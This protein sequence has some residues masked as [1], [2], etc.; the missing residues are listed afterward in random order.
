MSTRTLH[1]GPVHAGNLRLI[2]L[3]LTPAED[4]ADLSWQDKALCAEVD[5][6][7]FYTEGKGTS[8][9]P[10]ISV[11]RGCDVRVRCLEYALDRREAI[12]VWGG[13]SE[14]ARIG[15]AR[16]RADGKSLEDIIADDDAAFY[17]RLE[18][19]DER[20]GRDA[21]AHDRLGQNEKRCSR[22]KAVKQLDQFHRAARNP[23]GRAYWCKACVRTHQDVR[24]QREHP[25]PPDAA[26]ASQSPQPEEA[27]A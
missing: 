13:F 6:D 8:P 16:Q 7:L 4:T 21:G 27:V 22:C 17:T 14:R 3:F 5:P 11:C 1:G 20:A 12:G 25:A 24:L 23:G 9:A 18:K 26:I 10:A 2:D 19:I 15:V